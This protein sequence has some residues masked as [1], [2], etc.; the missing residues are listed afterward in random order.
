[1]SNNSTNAAQNTA[2]ETSR[3]TDDENKARFT[4]A[5]INLGVLTPI[6]D[7]VG[8]SHSDLCGSRHH[9]RRHG[10]TVITAAVINTVTKGKDRLAG[11]HLTASPDDA[12]GV[13]GSEEAGISQWVTGGVR[14]TVI[15]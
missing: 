11:D 4:N 7:N 3:F 12:V 5:C 10:D 8:R 13:P 6:W 9:N 15:S 1:M 14:S 2:P